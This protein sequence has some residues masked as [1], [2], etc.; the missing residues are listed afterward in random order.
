MKTYSQP[1][2]PA[3]KNVPPTPS[4]LP[5]SIKKP[6]HPL[7]PT[8]RNS[9]RGACNIH[10]RWTCKKSVGGRSPPRIF[11]YFQSSR[12]LPRGYLRDGKGR[13]YRGGKGDTRARGRRAGGRGQGE[14]RVR[15]YFGFLCWLRWQRH[16]EVLVGFLGVMYFCGAEAGDK[17]RK[18][19]FCEW[20]MIHLTR[21]T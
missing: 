12:P 3:K 13:I 17:E 7:Y 20:A 16:I 18:I 9:E 14:T 6:L 10:P 15:R 5:P 11:E 1:S 21:L 19:C 2:I 8:G 4:S